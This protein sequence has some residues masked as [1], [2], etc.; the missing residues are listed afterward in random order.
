MCG[1]A[2]VVDLAGRGAPDRRLVQRMNDA[3]AHR[4]P[5][6]D[7][8][9]YA[10]GVGIG[11][12]RLAIIDLSTGDQ[13]MYAQD[14]ALC[15]VFNG[16]IYNFKAVRAELEA[17]GHAF[18]T[19]SDTEVIL[20][21]YEEWGEDCVTRLRGMFVFALW[22]ERREAL[23]LARD[24][25]GKKPLYYAHLDD[26]RLLFASELKSLLLCPE[27]KRDIDL[28][29]VEDYFALGY[30]PDPRSIYRGV[31]KLP[32]AT[33]LFARR[34]RPLPA[35]RRYWSPLP[36]A[37]LQGGEAELAEELTRRLREAVDIRRVSDVPLGCFLSGGVDSS[38]VVAMMA[39][40]SV[41]PVETFSIAFRQKE[42][43]ESDYARAHAARYGAN[44]HVREV[45]ADDYGLLDRLVAMFDEPFADS[46]ALPT[47]RVASVA[48]E[49]VTVALSGDGGDELFA[50]YR[51]YLWHVGEER[52][53]R[54]L[55]EGAR[56]ALFGAL[57]SLYPKLDWA[58]RRLRAKATFQE[59]ALDSVGG[60]FQ[61]V[62]RLN[63]ELRLGL[64]SDGFRRSLG[65][66]HASEV[67]RAHWR[68]A[69]TD[70]PLLAAQYVDLMTWLPGDILV[71]ADR[72]S[73]A[74]SLEARAPLLDHELCEWAMALPL[75]MKL[76]GAVGKHLLKKAMEPYVSPDILHR[77][78]MGFSVPL[79]KWFRGP[80]R[81]R[82]RDVLRSEQLADSGLLD[83]SRLGGLVERH[84]SG[85]RDHSAE[86]WSVL[87]FDG[88]LRQVHGGRPLDLAPPAA[89]LARAA[90]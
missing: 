39:G 14:G 32:P 73:M 78:K 10:P 67:L 17:K 27:L 71:K 77:P 66:Y 79:A 11:H 40:L 31:L 64:Y 80:L 74:A 89:S 38:A 29:A 16:E 61:S 7:G 88:F 58:P 81:E 90:G 75:E 83:M 1:L 69:D 19:K 8:F 3:I 2:G 15:L 41:E 35:P 68:E 57:G 43:D 47:F 25:L 76:K 70:D 12:R 4:G 6:G 44:H 5:D 28:R 23:L 26:G 85:A 30:V 54:M 21:A 62:S 37:R 87:M 59:L 18:R 82:V 86:L 22:D 56:R 42:Y 51:R 46:S 72:A 84:L 9:H 49:R 60:F 13:P 45:D 36:R 34:G 63:D 65:G 48:R 52:V 50:G 55:P 33:T 53:R 20:R 24:R